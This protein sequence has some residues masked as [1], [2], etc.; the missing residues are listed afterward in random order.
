[1]NKV[2]LLYRI[3]LGISCKTWKAV[4]HVPKYYIADVVWLSTTNTE[5]ELGW[6]GVVNPLNL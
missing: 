2:Q 6:E 5:E 3:M 1:M 4:V